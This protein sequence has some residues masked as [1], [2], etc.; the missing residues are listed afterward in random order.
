MFFPIRLLMQ[1]NSHELLVSLFP[2]Y[3]AKLISLNS[4]SS[5]PFF[6]FSPRKFPLLWPRA[7]LFLHKAR[8][9]SGVCGVGSSQP[10]LTEKTGLKYFHK[11][12]QGQGAQRSHG[13][14][15]LKARLSS[16]AE[17]GETSGLKPGFKGTWG[18]GRA[19][20]NLQTEVWT[21]CDV[22]ALP[23]PASVLQ[24]T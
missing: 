2:N 9:C 13:R 19:G 11:C 8:S 23:H 7:E 17:L 15:S 14:S 24:L 22:L 1:M 21:P 18:L 3:H 12:L 20:F 4:I 16:R 5:S 6:S 10:L